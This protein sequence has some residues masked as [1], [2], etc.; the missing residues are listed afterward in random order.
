M[1]KTDGKAALKL[2]ACPPGKFT[3][4]IEDYLPWKRQWKATMRKS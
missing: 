4:S 2:P 3:G 1:T